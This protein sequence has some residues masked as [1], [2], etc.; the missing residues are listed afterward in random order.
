MTKHDANPVIFVGAGPGDPKLV[1]VAGKEALEQADLVVYAGSLVSEEM[2]GWCRN[3]CQTVSSAGLNLEEIIAAMAQA[4]G[5]GQK[6][7]RLQTGDISLYGALPEQLAALEQR[8]ITY[9]ILPGVS[10]AFAA[11]AALGL[12]YT[13]PEVCQSLIFTRAGGRTPMR[14]EEELASMAAHGCSLAIY[15]SAAL[16]QEVADTLAKAYGPESPIVVVQRATWPDQKVLWTTAA[17]L[18]EDLRRDG[19]GRQALI[20]TGPAVA[21]LRQGYGGG[22]KSKLYDKTYSHGWR[23]GQEGEPGA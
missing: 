17:S 8:G 23:G 5:Q 6:V 9:L 20:L 22:A 4:H 14:R 15:L 2:L 16:S 10:A 1:T 13:L 18:A 3:D 11:A 19:I 12:S 21:E 7:V